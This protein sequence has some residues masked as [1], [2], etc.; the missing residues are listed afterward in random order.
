M[1]ILE[2]NQAITLIEKD[3]DEQGELHK[4]RTWVLRELIAAIK[5]LLKERD[6][7]RAPTPDEAKIL[8]PIIDEAV[9]VKTSTRPNTPFLEYVSK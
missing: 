7:S 8:Q 9:F 1:N 5:W 6:A 4:S 2:L 3:L